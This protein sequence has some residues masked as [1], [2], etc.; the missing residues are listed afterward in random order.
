MISQLY[1]VSVTFRCFLLV[2]LSEF[3]LYQ[4]STPQRYVGVKPFLLCPIAP[5]VS[6]CTSGVVFAFHR[7]LPVSNSGVYTD[8]RSTTAR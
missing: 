4:S 8:S 2:E 6:V 1:V 7:P 5:L 3:L